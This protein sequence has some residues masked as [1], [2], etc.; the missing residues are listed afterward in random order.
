MKIRI[1]NVGRYLSDIYRH[2]WYTKLKDLFHLCDPVKFLFDFFGRLWCQQTDDYD[3][4]AGNQECRKQFID[5]PDT[6][7]RADQVFP[8]KYHG[9]PA[10]H[11]G[12]CAPFAGTFPEQGKQNNR[13]ECGTESSPGER[14]NGKY[15]TV[16]IS[17]N[18]CGNDRNY[19]ECNSCG[20]H[21]SVF[22]GRIFAE[23]TENV[24]RN[25]R[26]CSQQLRVRSGHGGS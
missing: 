8:D 23:S 24:G 18:E 20:C 7:E 11:T 1:K 9:T 5:V 14:N 26:R 6:T 16:R 4:S 12:K 17:G 15:G 2:F 13:S 3:R 21:A 22:V 19:K 25:R 10:D